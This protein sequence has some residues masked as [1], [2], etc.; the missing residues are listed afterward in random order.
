MDLWED[1]LTFVPVDNVID[2]GIRPT[3]AIKSQIN[4]EL[5]LGQSYD[6]ASAM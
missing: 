3:T 2:A 4:L 5:V 1:F 6:G